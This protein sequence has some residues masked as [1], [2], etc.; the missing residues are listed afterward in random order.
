MAIFA[1]NH[2]LA[3]STDGVRHRRN[4]THRG[5]RASDEKELVAH[6]LSPDGSSHSLAFLITPIQWY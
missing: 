5:K 6:F 3:R 4:H 2:M 1:S